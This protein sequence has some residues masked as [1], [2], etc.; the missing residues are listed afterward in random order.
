[1]VLHLAYMANTP[2]NLFSKETKAPRYWLIQITLLLPVSVLVFVLSC[3]PH[4]V[5]LCFLDKVSAIQ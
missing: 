5:S 3:G 4:C 2:L 1:M